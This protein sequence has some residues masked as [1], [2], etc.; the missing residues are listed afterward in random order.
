MPTYKIADFNIQFLNKYEFVDAL[1]HDYTCDA[2]KPDY[3]IGVTPQEIIAER[4]LM[5]EDFSLGYC[6]ATC[7][8]RK[9]CNQILDRDAFLLHCAVVQSGNNAYAF[10]GKSGAGKST[11][12][13]LWKQV[14]GDAVTII[15]CDKP[16]VRL[17]DGEFFAYG[18]PWSG[19]ERI[20]VNISAKIVALCFIEQSATNRI[21]R[22]NAEQTVARYFQQ[23]LIP[24]DASKAQKLLELTDSF[25]GAV[26]A[27]LLHCDISRAAAELSY[28]TL[29]NLR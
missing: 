21:E 16:I 9:L 17:V 22:L 8:Y 19:K 28:N 24:P 23:L 5:G 20:S 13:L 18:T 2:C 4:A 12:A 7:L 14:Y 15:N 11:H 26:P 6:E 1:C 25:L 29:I 10:L 3:V 27:Y